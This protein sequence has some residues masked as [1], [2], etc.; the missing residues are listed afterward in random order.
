MRDKLDLNVGIN[1]LIR[2]FENSKYYG[3]MFYIG[4]DGKSFDCFDENPGAKKRDGEKSEFK[5]LL[6]KNGIQIYKGVQQAGRTDAKVSAIN[7]IL[8]VNSKNTIDFEDLKFFET[9]LEN[10]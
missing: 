3:Y 7:N 4:Y 1:K 5:K 10:K 2:D 6:E 9:G 8:Y